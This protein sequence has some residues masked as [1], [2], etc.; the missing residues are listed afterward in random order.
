[1]TTTDSTHP[2]VALRDATRSND[3]GLDAMVADVDAR[4]GA[5]DVERLPASDS[6]LATIEVLLACGEHHPGTLRVPLPGVD[7]SYQ[8]L[9]EHLLEPL[10]VRGQREGILPQEVTS[11]RLT[12]SLHSLIAGL[13]PIALFHREDATTTARRIRALFYEAARDA[14]GR[15]IAA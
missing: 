13:L 1:M 3:F 4:L 12:A 10:V 6:L 2:P 15:Q 11:T 5:L 14:A 8:A 9:D 7:R